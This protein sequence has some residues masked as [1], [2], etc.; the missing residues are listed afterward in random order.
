MIQAE[1]PQ[2]FKLPGMPQ[3]ARECLVYLCNSD[4]DV[5][6][7]AKTISR[8]IGVSASILKLANSSQ[9]LLGKG[10]PTSDLSRAIIRIGNDSLRQILLLH[11]L[12]SCAQFKGTQFFTFLAFCNHS[13]FVSMV[14]H[15]IANQICPEDAADMQMAG[16]MHDV[17]LAVLA[18][19]LPKRMEMLANECANNKTDFFAEENRFDLEPHAFLSAR[20][21]DDWEMPL[22]VKKIIMWHDIKKPEERENMEPLTNKLV[23]ILYLADILAHSYGYGYKGYQRDTRIEM[24]M[25]QRLGLTVEDI[26][27]CVKQC[28]EVTALM[29]S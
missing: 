29:N 19:E 1:I 21:L 15:K 23:D 7:M 17:G 24:Q 18:Q 22:R 25:I 8:D 11:S 16:L 6:V 20:L 2:G 9:F 14:C 4:V 12:K 28:L 27:S 10:P 5:S 13:N 26:K 3:V